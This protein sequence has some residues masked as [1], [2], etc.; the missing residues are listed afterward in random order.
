M[1]QAQR[2]STVGGPGTVEGGERRQH[3]GMRSQRHVHSITPGGGWAYAS[4]AGAT[5]RGSAGSRMG[6]A[7]YATYYAVSPAAIEAAAAASDAVAAADAAAQTA[8][9]PSR[10][11]R[12]CRA[13]G[14]ATRHRQLHQEHSLSLTG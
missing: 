2:A 11:E 9:A 7:G 5:A 14:N 1:Q 13:G 8:L 3:A 6:V 12:A 4:G 10:A